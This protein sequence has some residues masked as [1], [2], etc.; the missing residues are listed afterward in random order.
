MFG[1]R[2]AHTEHVRGVGWF[3][4]DGTSTVT[5]CPATGWACVWLGASGVAGLGAVS[6]VSV[7]QR[8]WREHANGSGVVDELLVYRLCWFAGS[9][10]VVDHAV[11]LIV[12]VTGWDLHAVAVQID[13]LAEA[14]W[15]EVCGGTVLLTLPPAVLGDALDVAVRTEIGLAR[16]GALSRVVNDGDA[17]VEELDVA[18]LVG[19]V[20]D[21]VSMVTSL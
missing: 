20:R 13:S 1:V 6:F 14:G 21:V 18:R 2:D 19:S 7:W 15:V 5:P 4:T 10:R 16:T 9:G 8:T 17:Y 11:A 12:S 3:V